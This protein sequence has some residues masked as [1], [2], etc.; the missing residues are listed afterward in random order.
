M[1]VDCVNVSIPKPKSV[2]E[3]EPHV[4]WS[5]ADLRKVALLARV[6]WRQIKV[7]VYIQISDFSF[8]CHGRQVG[9]PYNTTHAPAFSSFT[10][11]P[12]AAPS[13]NRAVASH[14]CR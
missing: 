2:S 13:P 5:V 6:S 4:K 7:V 8:G 10:S 11:R 9:R 12:A 3:K 14:S 1:D